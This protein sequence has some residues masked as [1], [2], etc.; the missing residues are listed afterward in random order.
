L[1][2]KIN[3]VELASSVHLFAKIFLSIYYLTLQNI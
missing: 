1:Y 2:Q 3:F